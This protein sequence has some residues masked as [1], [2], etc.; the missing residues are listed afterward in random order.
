MIRKFRFMFDS[1]IQNHFLAVA[2]FKFA[3]EPGFSKQV[4]KF[5]FFC[6]RNFFDQQSFG[7][8][9]QALKIGLLFLQKSWQVEFVKFS[10]LQWLCCFMAKSGF[11]KLPFWFVC[12]CHIFWFL[13]KSK[14]RAIILSGLWLWF[15]FSIGESCTKASQHSV[16][17]TSG[18]R[19]VF[20]AVFRLR[21][22]SAPKQS[23]RPPTCG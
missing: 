11:P 22:F 10:P 3:F 6:S 9:L 13:L 14:V 21:A 4:F 2:F 7:S 23:P 17:P 1:K 19:R 15:W 16:Q 12:S 18:I 20:K 5:L 8:V